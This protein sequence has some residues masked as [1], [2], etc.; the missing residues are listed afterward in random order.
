MPNA[1]SVAYPVS[2]LPRIRRI[3]LGDLRTAVKSGYDDF[4]ALP[5]HAIFLCIIYPIAGILLGG[6]VLR[7]NVLPLLFPLIAG[8]ALIGP[9]A[10]VGL[11]E[12]SRRREL[13]LDAS[14]QHAFDVF[15]SPAR[16]SVFGLGFLLM[17][18]FVA[19]LGVAQTLY[20]Q[21]FGDTPP[22]S[23]GAFAQALFHTQAGWNLIL[24]GNVAG[25]AFAVVS[26][27]VGVVSFPLLI[28]RNVG[29]PVAMLTSI[30]AVLA[31][32][33]MLALWGLFVAVSLVVGS[34]PFLVG[35]IVVLPVLGHAS[36]HLYRRIVEL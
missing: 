7:Y 15:R 16:W 33:V 10:A 36:W 18:L 23:I 30:R 6:I 11:Y 27:C 4:S 34:L 12:L 31:N 25:F 13:G 21:T 3:T 26:L 22:A 35:L 8:F 24:W 2:D 19:W 17:L 9:F 29:V 1:T 5:S 32:P 28:D 14:W 20:A